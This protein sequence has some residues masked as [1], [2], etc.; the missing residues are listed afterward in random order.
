M[1]STSNQDPRNMPN[2]HQG[3]ASV[4]NRS[5]TSS[6]HDDQC[7][8]Y[9]AQC[10]RRAGIILLVC[11]GVSIILAVFQALLSSRYDIKVVLT[12]P[13]TFLVNMSMIIP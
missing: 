8:T 4:V 7:N 2:G 9:A 3:T 11:S 1:Q 13:T 6:S 10:G 5:V 12:L